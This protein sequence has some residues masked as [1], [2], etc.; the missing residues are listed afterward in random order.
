MSSVI[1]ISARFSA[2]A[3]NIENKNETVVKFMH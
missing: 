2:M 3:L 1:D